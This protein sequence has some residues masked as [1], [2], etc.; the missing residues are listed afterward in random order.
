[1]AEV[2]KPYPLTVLRRFD[3]PQPSPV[4]P[5]GLDAVVVEKFMEMLRVSFRDEALRSLMGSYLRG[6]PK[7][8]LQMLASSRASLTSAV[9][10][11]RRGTTGLLPKRVMTRS[12]MSA[13]GICFLALRSGENC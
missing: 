9:N 3:L 7:N 10:P 6:S 2:P 8:R 4:I 1:M 5:H 12:N 11:K 13:R